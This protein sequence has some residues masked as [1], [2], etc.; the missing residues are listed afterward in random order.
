LVAG[1]T[2]GQIDECPFNRDGKR[3]VKITLPKK[4]DAEKPF[5]LE[6]DVDRGAA[7]YPYTLPTKPLNQFFCDRSK[8]WG[9]ELNTKSSPAYVEVAA[10][11]SATVTIKN[12]GKK[13]IAANWGDLQKRGAIKNAS[14]QLEVVDRGR[15]WVHVT[16][17]DDATGK[18]ISCRVHFRSPEGIPYQ[19]H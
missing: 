15:N 16:V 1:I 3:P 8:G 12:N 18:P 13:L 9:E 19:P 4:A 6:V 11:K 17:V 7:T 5:K 14:A 2:L 10:T